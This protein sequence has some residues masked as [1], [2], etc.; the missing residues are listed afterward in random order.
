MVI[1]KPF[2]LLSR[3]LILNRIEG[4]PYLY[5]KKIVRTTQDEIALMY[6]MNE[7]QLKDVLPIDTE[8]SKIP[9]GNWIMEH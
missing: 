4:Y 6:F 2:Q 1:A 5:S 7:N 3:I 8:K 9:G